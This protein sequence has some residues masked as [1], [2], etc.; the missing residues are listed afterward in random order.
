VSANTLFELLAQHISDPDTNWSL[1]T[2]GAIAEF[3][4]DPDEPTVLVHTA[5]SL[6]AA[7]ARGGIRITPNGDIRPIASETAVGEGWNHRVALCL[8]RELCAMSGRSVLTEIGPDVEALGKEH[9]DDILFDLGLDCLQ[10]DCCIRVSDP[11][12]A[13]QL[14]TH[15]GR[16]LFEP[17][18][19]AMGV[20][21]AANPHR[22]FISRLGRVE[23]FQPIPPAGGTSPQ[24]P[25][26]HVLPKLLGHRRTHAATEP[27]P[28]HLVPCAH[29]YPSHPAK[30]A[31]GRPRAFDIAR[32]DAFQK[33]LETYGDPELVALKRH[34]TAAV[35]AGEE[36]GLADNAGGRFA[37]GSVRVALH[38]LRAVAPTTAKLAAW[39]AA[40]GNAAHARAED[41]DLSQQ[42]H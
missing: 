8:P 39:L 35:V 24:G 34:V 41:Q 23:V 40:H 4:R 13:A 21:L 33:L 31:M 30:D 27:I 3:V 10:V 18:N 6:S 37:R 25:H 12:V 26:T 42:G 16:S 20:I 36:P 32:H 1:G 5:A 28:E 2:F 19:Q 17:G 7:T 22:V 15:V 11:G 9:R 29:L 14:R 38:Q